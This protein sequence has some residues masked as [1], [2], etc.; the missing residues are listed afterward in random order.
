MSDGQSV[1]NFPRTR[2]GARS[3]STHRPIR[4]APT[5]PPAIQ[6]YLVSPRSTGKR[7]VHSAINTYEAVRARERGRRHSHLR[8]VPLAFPSIEWRA[9][10]GSLRLHFA[11]LPLERACNQQLRM[12]VVRSGAEF[13]SGRCSLR[14]RISH[15]YMWIT[16]TWSCTVYTA[17]LENPAPQI[18]F[19]SRHIH[20][21][22][23][24][25]IADM[26]QSPRTEL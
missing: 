11:L 14:I 6:L 4:L 7:F 13:R 15:E 5:L 3:H 22:E 25:I 26:S 16:H 21:Y 23:H 20:T 10:A 9:V 24:L 1:L 17:R 18:H 8:G 19:A 12:S 2:G